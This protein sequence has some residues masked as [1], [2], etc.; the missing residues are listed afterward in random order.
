[1]PLATYY[2]SINAF[3]EQYS[4][5]ELG[6]INHALCAAVREELAS[7]NSILCQL[8]EQFLSSSTFSLQ[9][10]WFYVQPAIHAFSLIESLIVELLAVAAPGADDSAGSDDDDSDLGLANEGL[11]G[12]L[13][14]MRKATATVGTATSDAWQSGPAK[15][16]EVLAIVY[17]KLSSMSGDPVARELYRK[18]FVKAS[19]PYAAILLEWITTGQLHDPWDEFIVREAKGIDRGSLDHDYTDEYWERRYTLRD[20]GAKVVKA[21]SNKP[22]DR[23]LSGGAVV[24]AF[25]DKWKTKVLLAGKYLNVIRE[26]GIKV[27]SVVDDAIATGALVDMDGEG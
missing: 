16:G 22:R 19:Q 7:Y 15:G 8:E 1:M 17:D 3:I 18:L 24:P 6:V 10:M 2:T 9:K 23:G 27:D 12:V 14:E 21:G 5:L 20:R 4:S 26:C 11:R 13:D 25:L